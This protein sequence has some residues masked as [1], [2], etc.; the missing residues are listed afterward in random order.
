ML[1]IL[2]FAL[3]SAAALASALALADAGVRGRNAFRLLRDDLAR[4]DSRRHV[5]VTIVANNGPRMPVL[6]WA[7]LSAGR[8]S[9]RTARVA[10]P[11]PLCAAA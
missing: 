10:A 8:L 9:R 11:T 1:A 6:R 4:H 7:S 2:L 3:F 5:T